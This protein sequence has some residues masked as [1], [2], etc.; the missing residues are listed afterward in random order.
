M[1]NTSKEN[2]ERLKKIGQDLAEQN[3]DK[4]EA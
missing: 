4:L 2:L 1:D 3:D